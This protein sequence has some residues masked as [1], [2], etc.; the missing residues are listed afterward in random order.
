MPQAVAE[1]PLEQP[2]PRNR[3]FRLLAIS[4][5]I[6]AVG[7]MVAIT[8]LPLLVL[9]LTGS[10]VAM[11]AV[12]AIG[13]VTDFAVALFAGAL[14]DRTDR[15]RLMVIADVGRAILTALVP[16]SVVAGGPT[17]AVIL[18]V[19]APLALLRSFFRAGYIASVPAIV[20][21]EH[22]AR[23]NGILETV[24][25]TAS[26]LGPLLA[27]FLIAAIGPGLTLA[28][29]AASFAA[30]AAGLFLMSARIRA[31]GERRPTRIIDDVREGVWYVVHHPVLRALISYFA[32]FAMLIGPLVVALAVRIT[33]DLG[34]EDGVYG[35]ALAAFSVGT[36]GGGLVAARLGRR[37]NVPGVFFAGVIAEGLASIGMALSGSVAVLLLLSAISGVGEALV[38]I[39]YISARAANSPD[40]LLGR[41]GSTARFVSLGIQ[42]V[43]F[44]LGGALID[45][46]GGTETI[47]IVGVSMCVLALAFVPARGLR[48]ASVAP[49]TPA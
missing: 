44:V 13:A 9:A 6:S 35:L 20:G 39:V 41:V 22:L 7:D 19:A 23:A 1:R 12:F 14:A 25:S 24:Q 10:G 43:G 3:D 11:G 21:R 40:A 45:A 42:P 32:L 5:A 47:A 34:L 37:T 15:K 29:D 8:A 26:V 36:V 2:F 30:S 18:V 31:A 4:Q 27:A 17:M 48:A 49:A 38:S 28:V 33:R 16:L 46:V